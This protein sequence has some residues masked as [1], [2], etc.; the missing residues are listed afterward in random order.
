MPITTVRKITGAVMVLTSCR[1]ASASHLASLAASGA[2]NPNKAPAP[3]ATTTQ[4]HSCASTLRRR[5][6]ETVCMT[7]PLPAKEGPGRAPTARPPQPTVR[8]RQRAVTLA[9]ASVIS[10]VLVAGATTG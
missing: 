9:V 6:D 7:A 5:P 10:V 2:T 3:M 1:K 4:N 8:T